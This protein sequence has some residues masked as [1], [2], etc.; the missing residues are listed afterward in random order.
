M[1]FVVKQNEN[2][3]LVTQKSAV[4]DCTRLFS[5]NY[6]SEGHSHISMVFSLVL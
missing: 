6:M 4:C 2:Y 3:V 5:C 1:L